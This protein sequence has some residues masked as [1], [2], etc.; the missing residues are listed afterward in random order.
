MYR[1]IKAAPGSSPASADALVL[2]MPAG[3]RP[4]DAPACPDPDALARLLKQADFTLK[5][6]Q[7][8]HALPRQGQAGADAGRRAR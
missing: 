5:P 4:A 7:A 2:L 3:T 1:S 6:E 8:P